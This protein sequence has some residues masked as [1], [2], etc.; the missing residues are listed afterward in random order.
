MFFIYGIDKII[1]IIEVSS[2]F[3]SNIFISSLSILIILFFLWETCYM[4]MLLV[5][6]MNA[7]LFF[8]YAPNIFFVIMWCVTCMCFG[9]VWWR[10]DEDITCSSGNHSLLFGA[11]MTNQIH[12]LRGQMWFLNY[13]P[14]IVNP[15]MI[16]YIYIYCEN[17]RKILKKS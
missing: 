17:Y 7:S 2:F 5:C 8:F 11:R 12:V 9:V 1:I 16:I 6:T 3:S 13:I 10:N 15:W 4:C 14:D